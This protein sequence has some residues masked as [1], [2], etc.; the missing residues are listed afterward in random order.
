MFALRLVFQGIT[1]GV[2]G[3]LLGALFSVASHRL[4]EA[5]LPLLAALELRRLA[6]RGGLA[7][8][9]CGVAALLWVVCERQVRG[10]GRIR[11]RTA[12]IERPAGRAFLSLLRMASL[13]GFFVMA[14]KPLERYHGPY[15]SY[16]VGVAFCVATAS[17]L[18]LARSSLLTPELPSLWRL[19]GATVALGVGATWAIAIAAGRAQSLATDS[20]NVLLITVDT[21]RGDHL[22]L[23]GYGRSTSPRLDLLA[24]QGRV[25]ERAFSHAPVTGSAIASIMTGRLPRQTRTFGNDSL[26]RRSVTLAE[27]LRNAGYRTGAVVSNFVLLA[28]KGFSDGFEDYDHRLE[29]KELNRGAPERSASRTT[30]AALT[31]LRSARRRPFFLWVHY[32]DPHGPYTPPSPYSEMF[33]ADAAGGPTLPVGPTLGSRRSIPAYQVLGARREA[34]YYV[35]QYDGEIRF[36]DEALGSLFDGLEAL[37]LRRRT[38]IVL[39]ADHGEGMGENDYYFAHGEHLF[40]GL[41]RIPLVLWH[42]ALPAGRSSKVVQH[43]D[44]APTVLRVAGILPSDRL[45]GRDLL[46]DPPNA[47]VV[48]EAVPAHGRYLLSVTSSSLQLVYDGRRTQAYDPLTGAVLTDGTELRARQVAVPAAELA[49]LIAERPS[50]WSLT[51][52]PTRPATRD[53]GPLRGLG[54]IQ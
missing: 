17:I 27:T 20:T 43:I 16:S 36:L 30:A 13:A 4:V 52:T 7:G 1:L 14:A 33:A 19:P 45:G 50:L 23:Y 53:S 3:G 51:G 39:T 11:G 32:Q 31:W 40:P 37:D 5:Q 47:V 38:L 34:A 28:R 22:G 24:R 49:Q 41:L 15:D 2:G 26:E 21:L 12:R 9:A 29:E 42:E 18:W 46:G 25:F 54:Y 8:L 48:S 35:S 6:T 10:R 44:I